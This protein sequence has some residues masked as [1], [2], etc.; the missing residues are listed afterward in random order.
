[1]LVGPIVENA[2]TRAIEDTRKILARSNLCWSVR[3]S[4]IAETAARMAIIAL[5]ELKAANR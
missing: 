1:M 4:D 2:V 5:E 3:D